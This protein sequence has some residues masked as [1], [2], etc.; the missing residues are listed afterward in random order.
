[1]KKY[2]LFTLIILLT[3]C[4]QRKEAVNYQ[5]RIDSLVTVIN[6]RDTFI[7]DF[8]VVNSD[9]EK[10]LDS[11]V[12]REGAISMAMQKDPEFRPSSRDRINADIVAINNLMKENREK[13]NDLSRKLKDS[14]MKEA[15]FD[16]MIQHLHERLS[17][18]DR[19]LMTLNDEL[20]TTHAQ[21]KLLETS[22]NM[23]AVQNAKQAVTIEQQ[24][25]ALHTA[26]YI[27]GKSGELRDKKIINKTGGLLGLGKTEQLDPNRDKSQFIQIDITKVNEIEINSDYAKIIT[28]H[29]GGS[30]AYVFNKEHKKVA[31]IRITNPEKFWSTSKYLVVIKD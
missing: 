14:N 29:P 6:Q 31:K 1:M 22:V 18:K 4:G 20:A 26:Y 21:L 15:E 17:D 16:K 30:Y 7:N 5:G 28:S 23:L 27:V 2:I 25:E 10:S 12:I 11:I 13:I 19:E 9:I 8:M 3:A 24:A